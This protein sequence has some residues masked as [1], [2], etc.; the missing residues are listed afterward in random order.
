[1]G[2]ATVGFSPEVVPVWLD[3]DSDLAY[4]AGPG[5]KANGYT[6]GRVGST[7]V[8]A[9]VPEFVVTE[10]EPSDFWLVTDP[11]LSPFVELEPW[12]DTPHVV[13]E[14]PPGN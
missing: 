12:A 2:D 1:M 7:V 8:V 5:Q 14:S 3:P 10:D 9:P 13:T 4:Y 6:V 11:T